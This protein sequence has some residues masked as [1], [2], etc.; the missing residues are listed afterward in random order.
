MH[1]ERIHY[2]KHIREGNQSLATNL[3]RCLDIQKTPLESRPY[4]VNWAHW[5]EGEFY[6]FLIE[7]NF[8]P[9]TIRDRLTAR[10]YGVRAALESG[11]FVPAVV[12]E[13]EGMAEIVNDAIMMV[14]A[15]IHSEV[16]IEMEKEQA[17]RFEKWM[18]FWHSQEKY[19]EMKT[20]ILRAAF[21]QAQRPCESCLTVQVPQWESGTV[22]IKLIEE[23]RPRHGRFGTTFS[24]VEKH[25]K[26]MNGSNPHYYASL[27][28]IKWK[29]VEPLIVEMMR[30][31]E[32]SME[33]IWLL[34]GI[35]WTPP[36]PVQ[37][38]VIHSLQGED[39][40]TSAP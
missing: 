19:T 13:G 16:M 33:Q 37:I 32:I 35:N 28:S 21:V 36:W 39:Q 18:G 9:N 15:A 25:I 22:T 40:R 6:Q 29:E 3:N 31:G 7:H 8:P 12:L 34:T 11:K 38:Q 30:A 10:R 24:G 1:P 20:S 14:K 23:V 4:P 17:I 27:M 26:I 2:E 5:T